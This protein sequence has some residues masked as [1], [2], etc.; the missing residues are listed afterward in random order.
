VRALEVY[1]DVQVQH[2]SFIAS[3]TDGVI[4]WFHTLATF[5]P[6]KLPALI[7]LETEWDAQLVCTLGRRDE[8]LQVP[9]L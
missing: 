1:G 7:D 3:V 8:T 2:H 9:E 5:S 4:Y 6:R